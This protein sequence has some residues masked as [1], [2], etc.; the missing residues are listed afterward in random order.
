MQ[1]SY[2]GDASFIGSTSSVFTQT[3]NQAASSSIVTLTS[4]SNP[5][6]IGQPLTFTAVVS[7][8]FTGTP[9]GQV[10]FLDNFQGLHILP[11]SPVTMDGSAHAS[12]TVSSL[13]IGTHSISVVYNGDANFALNSSPSLPQVITAPSSSA[14]ALTSGASPS[15]FGDSLTFTAT[16][17]AQSMGTPTGTVTFVDNF[18]NSSNILA[19]NVALSNSGHASFATSSLAVGVHHISIAYSGDASFTPSTSQALTQVVLA[20]GNASTTGLTVN[21]GSSATLNFGFVVGVAQSANFVVTVTGSND[22]DSVVLM[23]GNV[24]MGPV[25]LLSAGQ[26]SL[27]TQLG[28]GVHSIHAIYLGNATSAGS[29]SSDVTVNRS[30]RPKLQ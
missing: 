1:V 27:N 24:Q 26:A 22:G 2:S 7:P 30:P 28:A 12:L 18:M 15:N 5:S 23:Q 17:A 25:L 9:T 3:V 4:G 14:V 8:Q 21:G 11:G 16:V 20:T 6:S 19:S 10:T 13:A 29:I